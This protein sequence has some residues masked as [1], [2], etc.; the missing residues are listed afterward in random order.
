M[1]QGSMFCIRPIKTAING[2]LPSPRERANDQR[3]ATRLSIIQ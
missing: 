1:D 2:A 3:V